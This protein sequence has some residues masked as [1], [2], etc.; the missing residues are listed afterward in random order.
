VL[1]SSRT[2]SLYVH[3]PFRL[4]PRAYDDAAYTSESPAAVPPYLSALQREIEAS[5]A[6]L[7]SDTDIESVFIGGG[8]PSLLPLED[9]KQLLTALPLASGASSPDVTIEASPADATPDYLTGL[10]ALGVTRLSLSGLSF[11][12][13]VLRAVDA[14]H[15]AA[16]VEQTIAAART[17]GLDT[18]ALD[19][20]FGMDGLSLE[21][22][23]ATLRR[24]VALDLPHVSIVEAASSAPE[25]IVAD[26]MEHA[27]SL[28]GDAGYEH[29]SLTHFAR[30]GRPSAHQQHHDRHGAVL[31]LGPSAASLWWTAP[32]AARAER[33]SN[34]EA[35]SS[36]V[37]RL[38]RGASP[39]AR[40]HVLDADDLAREYILI[41]LRTREGLSLSVLQD[42]YDLDLRA[43]AGPFLDRLRAEG[44][45]HDAPNRVRLT[46]RGRLLT[47][48]ITRRLLSLL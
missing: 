30:P 38:E 18:V 47:D 8:R 5:A 11:S 45:A 27:L 1:P 46:P 37:E 43:A 14:P 32:T 48:A 22:W 35:L 34:V 15:T 21:T 3:V 44:L 42:D 13:T 40:H 19:L 23:D 33:W 24:A 6:P 41:R 12:P 9:V 25:A 16:D 31:G 20:L 7:L 4:A 10:S 28:L 2:A 17:A 29:Y 26:Q 36:Y 39:T